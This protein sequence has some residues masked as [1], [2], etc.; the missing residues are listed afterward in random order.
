MLSRLLI[1]RLKAAEN[2]LKDGRYDEAFRLA[3]EPDIRQHRRG[4][5]VLA[6]LTERLLDRAR[7]HFKAD[8]FAEA[9]LDL[10]K[11]EA[12]GV[13]TAEI[14]ELREQVRVV[15][16]EELRKDNSRKLRLEAARAR[17]QR[18][19]LRAGERMLADVTTTDADAQILQ[20]Q[21]ADRQ[22][23]AT[24][25]L[26]EVERLLDQGQ[27]AQAIERWNRARQ[28]NATAPELA[29]LESRICR[30]VLQR[31][32]ASLDAR[33][34]QR[35]MDEMSMLGRIGLDHPERRE[36]ET[37]L[38][39]TRRGGRALAE[40]RFDQALEHM[41]RLQNLAPKLDWARQAV[42]ELKRVTEL[43]LS[44]RAGPLGQCASLSS[45]SQAGSAETVQAGPTDPLADTVAIASPAPGRGTLPKSMLMLVDGGG[46]FLLHRGNRVSLGRAAAK[47]PADVPI[48]SDI[49]ERH[50]E[51]SRVEDDYFLFA[52]RE[53]EVGGR[54]TRQQLL[55]DGERVVLGRRAK[56]A[57]RL[58]SRK[59]SSALLEMSDSTRLPNDVRRV[60]LLRETA[61][62]G[63]GRSVHVSCSSAN[64]ELLL[65]E[66]AGH[67][68]LR[69]RNRDGVASEAQ[70]ITLGKPMEMMGLSFVI[71]PWQPGSAGQRKV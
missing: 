42:N 48:L 15:A 68:W 27:A 64:G 69:P 67:L 66:R 4:A 57:F 11:A 32:R 37:I 26:H 53:V 35:M 6:G 33:R 54:R 30:E 50:A 36:L 47:D 60:I 58:P 25:D 55:R 9:L 14:A 44:L 70:L 45:P 1:V 7:A 46:S 24:E 12:G 19:S 18:G 3:T 13:K 63:F 41:M 28:A 2:A 56:F 59:S 31:A 29:E 43:L 21:V 51:I 34:M 38:D 65:F 16:E 39:Q 23:D 20:R 8:R 62:I 22:Q 52:S 10:T 61:M 49:S 71:E 40:N 5:A 17:I